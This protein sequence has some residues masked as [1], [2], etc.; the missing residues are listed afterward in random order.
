[1]RTV[2]VGCVDGRVDPAEVLEL[3]QG[4]AVVIRNVGGRV[5]AALYETLEILQVVASAAG[6]PLGEGWNLIVLHHTNCGIVPCFKHAPDLLAKNL[7]VSTSDLDHMAIADPYEAVRLDAAMLV[8]SDRL[9]AGLIVSGMV[10]DVATG[11]LSEV[12]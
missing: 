11:R 4:E 7:S 5:N 6:K 9:P 12:S 10:Y 8:S 2:I 3:E 1:M